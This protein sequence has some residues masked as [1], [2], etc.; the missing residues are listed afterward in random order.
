MI[1]KILRLANKRG[2][3]LI[4]IMVAVFIG[5]IVLTAVYANFLTQYKS[6]IAN[7]FVTEMQQ[8]GRVALDALT[9]ELR[10][11]GYG[12]FSTGTN[13]WKAF[14]FANDANC[15]WFPKCTNNEIVFAYRNPAYKVTLQSNGTDFLTGTMSMFTGTTLFV[16]SADKMKAGF[17]INKSGCGTCT[18]IDRYASASCLY[19]D[20]QDLGT[21]YGAGTAYQAK[22]AHFFMSGTINPTLD[23]PVLY[24]WDGTYK[25]S[26]G[27]EKLI[28]P[29][30]SGI[31]ALNFTYLDKDDKNIYPT[32]PMANPDNIRKV[33]VEITARTSKIDPDIRD[34][35]RRTFREIVL[36]RNM[37]SLNPNFN[38]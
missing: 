27:G 3:T 9:R 16:Q 34:Y 12:I 11:A 31:E 37:Y 36:I 14:I 33:I 24:Y 35:R 29:I 18:A 7:S 5:V 26:V 20:A 10:M 15:N 38:F 4:E 1:N 2:F 32:D 17:V 25:D 6:Y 30:A 21:N 22:Y 28:R 19:N 13:T 8:N 23:P